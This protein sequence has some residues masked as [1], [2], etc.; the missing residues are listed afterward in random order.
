MIVVSPALNWIMHFKQCLAHS[1][2]LSSGALSW[3]F[4]LFVSGNYVFITKLSRLKMTEEVL[5]ILVLVC[6]QVN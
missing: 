4:L 6:F 1:G 5:T 2:H 3:L